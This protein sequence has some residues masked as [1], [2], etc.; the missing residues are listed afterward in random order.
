MKWRRSVGKE[1]GVERGRRVERK[2]GEEENGEEGQEKKK[3]CYYCET[4]FGG[5]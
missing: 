5:H 4:D 2:F 3:E 1:V